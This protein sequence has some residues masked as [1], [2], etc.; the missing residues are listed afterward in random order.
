M[1]LITRQFVDPLRSRVQTAEPAAILLEPR[2]LRRVI[3]LDRRLQ[4]LGLSVPHRKCYTIERDRLLAY[5]DRSELEAAPGVDLPRTVILLA[6]PTEDELIEA[7]GAEAALAHYGRLLLHSSVH[8][9]LERLASAQMDANAWAAERLRE[10]GV[11]EVAEIRQVLL[12]DELLFPS[13]SELDI[14]VEFAAVYVELRYY[15]EQDLP[16]YFPGVRDWELIDRLISKDV[17]HQ[18]LNERTRL[19]ATTPAEEASVDKAPETPT[20]AAEPSFISLAEFRKTQHRAERAAALGNGIMAA[21][22]HTRAAQL[23][24]RG[25]AAEAHGSARRELARFAR[26]LQRALELSEHEADE[27]S[28]ALEPLLVPAAAGYWTTEARL[29]YD[30]QK[31]CIEQERNVYRLD[32]IEWIRTRGKRPLRRP[33][34]LLRDALI[35]R[36]LRTAE[37]R[38]AAAAIARDERSRLKSLIAEALGGVEQISRDRIRPLIT[39]ALD[40]VGLVPENVPE[41]VARRKLVEELVDRIVEHSYISMGDLRDALSKNDLK[42]PDVSGLY[43]LLRGDQLLQADRKLDGSLDGVYRRGATYMRWPQTISSLAFGT[44]VGRFLT[45]HVAI[46]F[47]GAYLTLEFIRHI[48]HSIASMTKSA[49]ELQDA[50]ATSAS[51]PAGAAAAGA[52]A[53]HQEAASAMARLSD[54]REWLFYS[55]VLLLGVWISLLIHRPAFRA[56]TVAALHN[57]WSLLRQVLI[58]LPQGVLHSKIVQTILNS[59]AFAAVHSY[60]IRPTIATGIMCAMLFAAGYRYDFRLA[61]EIF[62][63]CALVLN[64]PIGRNALELATDFLGRAWRELTMRV[65]AAVLQGIMEWFQGLVI[66]LERVVYAVDQFLRFRAGDNRA[67]Q[68]IKLLGGVLW[69]VVSYVVV[70]AFTLLIEPQINP[71]KHFPVVTV[72]HKFLLPL[73]FTTKVTLI[74]SPFAAMLMFILPLSI[75]QANWLAWSIVW[76]VPG[77][78]GFLVWELKENWRLYAAN[79][80]SHL[81]PVTIGHHGETMT[82]LLRPGFHS[83]TVP[84]AFAALRREARHAERS[85]RKRATR[86][87]AVLHD[88]AEAVQR[89]AERELVFLLQEINFVG[90]EQLKVG[91]VRVAT[92]RI[93][94]ELRRG[95]KPHTPSMLSWEDDGRMLHGSVS[96]EGWLASLTPHDRSV[97]IAAVGGLFQRA[98]VDETTGS[99]PVKVL[100]PTEWNAWVD[101][102]SQTPDAIPLAVKVG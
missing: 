94:V 58:E 57:S 27:W 99:L 100:P 95:D 64:S 24:P 86:K 72:A 12:K 69:F 47:G 22:W 40:D 11:T 77:V 5:V 87:Q 56:W 98:G 19:S 73:S 76:L 59:Q 81:R 48:P 55:C 35:I 29:L 50:V 16:I 74:A 92:N 9:E 41:Q 70:F 68:A 52:I 101:T 20:H 51:A 30:L 102:W 97:L 46:P 91:S 42:L 18:A 61:I 38:L 45:K 83:G 67:L 93:D 82:R 34:P 2:V 84:K 75:E 90:A 7:G 25:C 53:A 1:D 23:A 71:I 15:A 3:R 32:L 33:L 43:E 49:S 65:F 26:R 6:K 10:I 66:A 85:T 78:F 13:P 37:G 80:A 63:V 36:H 21:I 88:I 60:V 96:R 79:R 8:V 44:Q 89:F 17:D 14:Y 54:P 39:A 4:G 28:A 31:V 62:L